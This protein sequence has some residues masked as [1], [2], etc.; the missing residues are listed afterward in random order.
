[1]L[2]ARNTSHGVCAKC[3]RFLGRRTCSSSLNFQISRCEISK[4]LA[5]ILLSFPRSLFSCELGTMLN[6][7]YKAHRERCHYCP[8]RSACSTRFRRNGICRIRGGLRIGTR[9]LKTHILGQVRL[10]PALRR[11]LRF[12]RRQKSRWARSPRLSSCSK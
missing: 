6:N 4:A 10:S 8:F 12:A 11:T 5:T 2:S 9:F 3:S 7:G 1:M